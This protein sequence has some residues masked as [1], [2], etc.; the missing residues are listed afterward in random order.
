MQNELRARIAKDL[1]ITKFNNESE[2]EYNQ[3]L[4]YSAA[5]MWV[6]TLI[7][8]NSI[9]DIRQDSVIGYPDIMYVQSHLGKVIGAYIKSLKMNLDW[10][11]INYNKTDE[12]AMDLAGC[13]MQEMLYTKNL[14]KI[15]ER[16]MAAVPQRYF[17]YGDW[18][19]VRGQ[20]NYGTDLISLGV[21]QW[22]Q[23]ANK[24]DVID[25]PRVVS[26]KGS[27]YYEMMN[28]NF[29][30]K[31]ATLTSTYLIFKEGETRAYSKC[32][33]PYIPE[34]V[35][36]G[37]HMLKAA[38]EFNGGYVLVKHSGKDVQMATI[39]PWYIESHEI[40]RILYGLNVNNG[41]HAQFK[42]KDE[43]DCKVL[44]FA[45]ALPDYENRLILSVSW[46]YSHYADKY[47]RIIP[48][49]IWLIAEQMLTDLGVEI[50]YQ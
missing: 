9:S 4:V 14:A 19:Q 48:N 2:N 41:T 42:I 27:K 10:L 25:E 33:V 30:W 40:Y 16:K 47:A 44:Y 50:V 22:T 29:S 5:S 3:R 13:V 1:N 39:D 24:V 43:G 20:M 21:S 35:S 34:K 26:I 38:D 18:I 46:P 6:R 49:S 36:E 28:R 31:K 37:I 12:I 11:E 8:G 17:K 32:W 45:S 23:I 15:Y 7:Y